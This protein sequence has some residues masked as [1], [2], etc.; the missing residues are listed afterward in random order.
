MIW[1]RFKSWVAPHN[2]HVEMVSALAYVSTA[3]TGLSL[4]GVAELATYA[5]AR[6]TEDG[7]TGILIYNG[8]NFFQVV[9]GNSEPLYALLYRLHRDTRHVGLSLVYEQAGNPRA[10]GDWALKTWHSGSLRE[11]AG[12][13]PKRLDPQLANLARAFAQLR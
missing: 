13:L 8:R 9:E 6:N 12:E 1:T 5:Q 3:E 4:S 7:I 10:F 2:Q 11:V